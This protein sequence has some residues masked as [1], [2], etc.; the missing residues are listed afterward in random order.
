MN[1]SKQKLVKES[2][3]QGAGLVR[4]RLSLVFLLYGLDL[5]VA[6]LLAIPIYSA[7]VDEVGLTG[8]GPDL[9]QGFDLVLWRDIVDGL[10]E[11]LQVVGLQLLIIIPVYWLWKTASRMGVIYALHQGGIW[12]FWRGVGYYTAKGLL[13]GLA[14]I[15]VKIIAA[16]AMIIIGA[17]L[18]NVWEGEIGAFWTMAVITPF[19]VVF[20]LS[21]LDLFQR[22]ARI[23]VVVRHDTVGRALGAGFTWPFKY[24]AASYVYL[25]W[26]AVTT[27][28]FLA[29]MTLNANLHVGVSAI[30]VGFLIQQVSLLTR[31]AATVAWI[32]SEVCLF[33]RTHISEL[34]LI[35]NAVQ[36]SP[37]GQAMTPDSGEPL[38]GVAYT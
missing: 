9:I 26:F 30:L 7:V 37:T 27:V 29:T 3:A 13:I 20:V 12:P 38:G 17:G 31:T 28:V 5:V 22:Y 25:I 6:V 24:G 21:M 2:I 33:E 11:V 16:G 15:P 23:S 34:P 35:A 10:T 8:F 1:V 32:G 14:F 19:L 36:I 4:E 18:F